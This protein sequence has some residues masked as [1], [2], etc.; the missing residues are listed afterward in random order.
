MAGRHLRGGGEPVGHAGGGD[1]D[2]GIE[3]WG[4]ADP[5]RRSVVERGELH[6]GDAQH[7][8]CDADERSSGDAGDHR[9]HE[10]LQLTRELPTGVVIL[11]SAFEDEGIGKANQE[12][13]AFAFVMKEHL[14]QQ[15]PRLLELPGSRSGWNGPTQHCA[16]T[17]QVLD[18]AYLG[19][20][21]FMR[22]GTRILRGGGVLFWLGDAK[23]FPRCSSNLMGGGSG[24]RGK[25]KPGYHK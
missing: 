2:L 17:G 12:S 4:G 14:T 3:A 18:F 5:A 13:G 19:R 7:H 16:R 20:G 25:E 6:G 24:A 15:L 23:K 9:G 21:F 1:G 11:M 22:S 8:E 10:A